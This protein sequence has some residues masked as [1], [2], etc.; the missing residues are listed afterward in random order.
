MQSICHKPPSQMF[1]CWKRLG[2][3]DAGKRIACGADI[4]DAVVRLLHRSEVGTENSSS[5]PS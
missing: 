4:L 5:L 3:A 1:V 2:T